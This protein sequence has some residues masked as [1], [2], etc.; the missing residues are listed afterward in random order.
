[1]KAAR[2]SPEPLPEQLSL[3]HDVA[4]IKTYITTPKKTILINLS[5]DL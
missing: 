3:L 4:H 2:G 1:M 5:T